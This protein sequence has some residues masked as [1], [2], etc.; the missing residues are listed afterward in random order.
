LLAATSNVV[1]INAFQQCQSPSFVSARRH[2]SSSYKYTTHLYVNVNIDDIESKALEASETWDITSTSFLAPAEASDVEDR[3]ANRADVSCTRVPPFSERAKFVF[4]NPEL[5]IEKTDYY[6][7]LRLDNVGACGS[8]PWANVLDSIGVSLD[9][10]G[11]V[12][13]VD[14]EIVYMA[15]DPTVAKICSRLLPKELSGTGVT[16]SALE[17]DEVVPDGGTLQDMTF[18]RLDKRSQKQLYVFL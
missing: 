5:E 8:V 13:V 16:V 1:T 12:L 18:Q 4:T 15:V 2:K 14:N 9:N 10:V 3:L 17:S 11:D 7:I 6:T